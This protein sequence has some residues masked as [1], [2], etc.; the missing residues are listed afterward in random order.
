MKYCKTLSQESSGYWQRSRITQ[1][2][3]RA[4]THAH[5]HPAHARTRAH[6]HTHTHTAK[7]GKI[8]IKFSEKGNFY[9]VWWVWIPHFPG[10]Q[11]KMLSLFSLL[12]KLFKKISKTLG[13]GA[14]RF[15]NIFQKFQWAVPNFTLPP[16]VQPYYLFRIVYTVL[17]KPGEHGT[18]SKLISVK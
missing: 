8:K 6:T 3:A 7:K 2:R 5:T 12:G 1:T 15:T 18:A 9:T 10:M 16:S 17:N 14:I 4:R 11:K 13:P